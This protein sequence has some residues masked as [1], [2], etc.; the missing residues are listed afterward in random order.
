MNHLSTASHRRG[1]ELKGSFL[2]DSVHLGVWQFLIKIYMLNSR[3]DCKTPW[4]HPCEATY[5][6]REKRVV[7]D[8]LSK[9][10]KGEYKFGDD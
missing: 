7:F 2:R 1:K 5:S 4:T 3:K 8:I 9:Y 6:M 10:H